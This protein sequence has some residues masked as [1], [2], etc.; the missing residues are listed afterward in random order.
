MAVRAAKVVI[1]VQATEVN[2]VIS[3]HVDVQRGPAVAVDPPLPWSLHREVAL[4]L[5][6]MI[7]HRRTVASG[8]WEATA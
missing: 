2:A 4:V 7:L 8:S 6:D 5:T 1:V 3:E